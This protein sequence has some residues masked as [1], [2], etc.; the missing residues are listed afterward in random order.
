MRLN[1]NQL[2]IFAKVIECGG[3]SAAAQVLFLSQSSV[4]KQ[5]QN[6]EASLRTVLVDRSGPKIRPTPAGRVLL[7]QTKEMLALADHAVGAVQAAARWPNERLV[8]GSTAAV[9][10]YLLPAVLRELR[11]R[12]PDGLFT[13]VVNSPECLAGALQQGR[14]G[15]GV[16]DGPLPPGRYESEE[17][18]SDE[19]LLICAPD[20]P[21]AGQEVTP[22]DLSAESFLL[23]ES[24]SQ[25]RRQL[26]E[27]LHTWDLVGARTL[28]LWGTESVRE[29]VRIGLGISLVP[30]RS[31]RFELLH[32]VLAELH[33]DPGP[34]PRT[35]TA[36]W[37]VAR[38][39][40][41]YE[42][43]LLSLLREVANTPTTPPSSLPPEPGRPG[44]GS[45]PGS[46]SGGTPPPPGIPLQARRAA[47]GAEPPPALDEAEPSTRSR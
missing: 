4:S 25:T 23:L 28:D 41:P 10:D 2:A 6:L 38:P 9:G 21:L 45:G 8:V 19:M 18:A 47:G 40:S 3:F 30:R 5:V 36:N 14:I 39:L 1:L 20:H 34:T 31:V 26:L 24:G 7:A 44:P 11:R 32:G 42:E 27:L 13:V 33:V 22:A 35:V 43:L 17:L 15:V 29:A 12:E 46:G 16:A 37:T